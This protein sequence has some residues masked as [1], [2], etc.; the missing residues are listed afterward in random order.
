[1]AI[2]AAPIVQVIHAKGIPARLG[3]KLL[4]RLIGSVPLEPLWGQVVGQPMHRDLAADH[5]GVLQRT[6]SKCKL[7]LM[8]RRIEFHMRASPEQAGDFRSGITL[9]IVQR[10]HDNNLSRTH[11][12]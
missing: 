1:M 9:P 8:L 12:G 6:S 11:S 7:T 3:A 5:L 2:L 4:R 10:G